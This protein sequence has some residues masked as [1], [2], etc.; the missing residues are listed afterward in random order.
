MGTRNIGRDEQTRLQLAAE[1]ARAMVEGGITDYGLAKRKAQERMRLP[2]GTPLPSNRE[3]EDAVHEYLRLYGDVDQS[4]HL[5]ALREAAATAMR[6]LKEFK[7]RLVG[8]VLSGT[9]DRHSPVSLHL[10]ADSAEEVGFAL[11]ERGIPHRN[12]EQRLRMSTGS[13]ERVPG[14]SFLAGEIEL[15]MLVF[16]GR[17]RRHTPLS[18]VDGRAM[19][20]ASLADVEMLIGDSHA[21]I[22]G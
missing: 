13:V 16:S 20:R 19:R 11:M 22:S 18:P 5:T 15:Q 1:A 12:T 14:Y 21:E 4:R 2:S 9:A 8:P 10:F 17:T 3:I 7:P 6:E